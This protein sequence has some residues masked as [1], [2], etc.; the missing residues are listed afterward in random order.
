MKSSSLRRHT[1]SGNP[2][3]LGKYHHRDNG[4]NRRKNKVGP[5][6]RFVL[7]K[8]SKSQYDREDDETEP[9]RR[10]QLAP[11]GNKQKRYDRINRVAPSQPETD[12]DRQAEQRHCEEKFK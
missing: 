11:R 5:I 6:K 1:T 2:S 8:K 12:E 10:S 4:E 3:P 9:R 7:P